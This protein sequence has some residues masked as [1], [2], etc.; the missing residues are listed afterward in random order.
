MPANDCL[1]QDLI[2]TTARKNLAVFC[3]EQSGF[4]KTAEDQD[5][6]HCYPGLV[7]TEQ[8]IKNCKTGVNCKF[9]QLNNLK[10]KKQ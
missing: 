4:L 3:S 2:G 8:T 6:L 9:S 7:M 1:S 5:T 10:N